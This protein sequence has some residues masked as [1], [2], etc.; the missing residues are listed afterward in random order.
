MTT[1]RVASTCHRVIRMRR[2]EPLACAAPEV[3]PSAAVASCRSI[4]CKD[5]GQ[6]RLRQ[7]WLNWGAA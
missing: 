1:P 2:R 4:D 5:S 6:A 7:N 3:S